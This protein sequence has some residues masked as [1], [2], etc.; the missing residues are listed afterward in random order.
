MEWLNLLSLILN[1]C[2]KNRSYNDL[3]EIPLEIGYSQQLEYLNLSHNQIERIP[4]TIAHLHCLTEFNISNN[5]L[6]EI[7]PFIFTLSKL[8]TLNLSYNQIKQITIILNC[9]ATN[10][11]QNNNSNQ[12][13]SSNSSL[14]LL[15]LSYNQISILPA[16]I[17]QLP[18][19]RR[20]RLEGCPLATTL[21]YQFKLSH[22]PPSLLEI[23]AR[24]I[25]REKA[26]IL[27]SSGS[28]STLPPT[29]KYQ[30]IIMDLKKKKKETKPLMTPAIAIEKGE[31]Q[32]DMIIC[33]NDTAAATISKLKDTLT[34]SL[35]H[36]ISNYK[37]CSHC[38]GPYFTSFVSRGRWIDRNDTW[39]P[40][41]YRLCSAHWSTESDRIYSMFSSSSFSSSGSNT[42]GEKK[43]LLPLLAF[44]H[45]TVLPPL[46]PPP[47]INS[48]ATSRSKSYFFGSTRS[49]RQQQLLGGAPG[50]ISNSN[51]AVTLTGG[52]CDEEEEDSRTQAGLPPSVSLMT[53]T[54][55]QENL[56]PQ[57]QQDNRVTS[58]STLAAPVNEQ[59][60]Q[61]QALLTLSELQ[62]GPSPQ[63]QH[64]TTTMDNFS[65]YSAVKRWNYRIRS[66][67]SSLF[68]RSKNNTAG[69]TS[70]SF[71]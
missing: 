4:D 67:S 66:N 19:L 57:Q 34:E 43:D 17:T 5:Q 64:S 52:G 50:T 56:Q 27:P 68:L 49:N 31:Q 24:L 20:L 22:N 62:Q 2:I 33:N 39:I 45:A 23:C 58:S 12:K 28:T 7:T 14:T 1:L 15:D 18:F 63:P 71:Y 9:N 46:L 42:G 25:I 38:N 6:Q 48:L 69:S 44:I 59:Q 54:E 51:S 60:Q 40:L 70:A 36:Y 16:E 65:L 61:Q 10:S 3:R 11:L 8:Q 55:Q 13:E 37:L 26:K 35:Y 29:R 32:N 30:Q 41:E 53:I 21:D 47:P